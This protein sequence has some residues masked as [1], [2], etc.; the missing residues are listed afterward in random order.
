VTFARDCLAYNESVLAYLRRTPSIRVVVLSGNYARYAQAG[1][2]ALQ[3]DGNLG[4]AGPAD[5][6]A[7]QRR[8]AAAIRALGKRVVIVTG[9][10]AA[11]FDIGQCWARR[12]G[13]L[14]AVAPAQDCAI[15]DEA[16][17][18]SA[19]W[20]RGLFTGFADAGETPVVRLDELLCP[21]PGPCATRI[22]DVPLYR[23]AH[24]LGAAGS[25][26]VGQRWG[27][28]QRIRAAAR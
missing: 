4:P 22:G 24:H 18:V 10:V 16:R 28:A 17:A 21:N 12:Q 23:D 19:E 15:P 7:A 2:L 6:A 3:A 20:T 9:P 8:T 26:L 11:R 25:T 1:T 14:P 13:G 5:L 27:L